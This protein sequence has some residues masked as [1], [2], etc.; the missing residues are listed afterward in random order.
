[1]SAE[2][3]NRLYKEAENELR[4]IQPAELQLTSSKPIENRASGYKWLARHYIKYVLI[5]NKLG[6]CY[7]QMTDL[8]RLIIMRRLLDAA[9]GRLL[10]LKAELVREELSDFNYFDD[11]LIEMKLTWQDVDLIVPR[12]Y[13]RDRLMELTQMNKDIDMIIERKKTSKKNEKKEE[14][15]PPPALPQKKRR[16]NMSAIIIPKKPEISPEKAA[17]KAIIML[18]QRHERARTSRLIAQKLREMRRLQEDIAWHRHVPIPLDVMTK[19]VKNIQ[20]FW[21][22]YAARLHV[23]A[24]NIRLRILIGQLRSSYAIRPQKWAVE[25]VEEVRRR[26]RADAENK[27]K[28]VLEDSHSYLM[29]EQQKEDIGGELRYFIESWFRIVAELPAFPSD[30]LIFPPPGLLGL[31]KGT[32]EDF[33]KKNCPPVEP[34]GPNMALKGSALIVAGFWVSA[35]LYDLAWQAMLILKKKQ[36]GQKPP[37]K[38]TA[39]QIKEKKEQAKAEAL[40][41]KLKMEADLEEKRKRGLYPIESKFLTEFKEALEESRLEWRVDETLEERARIALI[42]DVH[43]DLREIVDEEIRGELKR[44][45]DALDKDRSIFP[46]KPKKKKKA[47]R[48]PKDPTKDRTLSSLFEELV[49]KGVIKKYPTVNFDDIC[50]DIGYCQWDLRVDPFNQDPTPQFGE[51]M[52]VL[53]EYCILNVMG[54]R[55]APTLQPRGTFPLPIRSVLLF[56]PEGS[57]KK[58]LVDAI[59]TQL[60]AV[61]FDLTPSKDLRENFPEK[62]DVKM[63][64]HLVSK[65]SRLLQ[66]T[67]IF[68]DGGEKPFY[69]KVPKNEKE[70]SPRMLKSH[71]PKLMREIKPNDR[72]IFVVTSNSPWMGTVR[73]MTKMYDKMIPVYKVNYGTI[74]QFLD[75]KLMSYH[76]IDRD[77]PISVL[78]RLAESYSL[79]IIQEAVEAILTPR[80]IIQLKYNPLSPTEIY[81]YLLDKKE[82]KI[83]PETNQMHIDWY[84]RAY[85]LAKARRT[86]LEAEAELRGKLQALKSAKNK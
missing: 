1:M 47:K 11:L 52:Q 68:I 24:R 76:G 45:N 13:R 69:T 25:Q 59:C 14:P 40:E 83:T 39:E 50:K 34:Q 3:Y 79:P 8:P 29:S 84:Q 44:L 64:V 57:G 32:P 77:F 54:P 33:I 6:L 58:T 15:P 30:E 55:F 73:S 81:D 49:E 72:V 4:D 17:F 80:R 19:A 63:L 74:Y 43:L 78:T 26:L 46:K 20:R 5:I 22:G 60:G 23:S 66:P 12:Y 48:G 35:E 56:G 85:P 31:P 82:A 65:V 27:W 70:N 75:E 61:K 38:L 62:K 16:S 71:L 86:K 28:K 53:K 2:T 9:V 67:V 36:A 10:E 37:P 18:L 7:D 21:R 51:I 41:R 42:K